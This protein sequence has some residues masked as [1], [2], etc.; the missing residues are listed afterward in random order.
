MAT[1]QARVTTDGVERLHVRSQIQDK[2]KVN[3][4][5]RAMDKGEPNLVPEGEE[6]ATGP[7]T[8]PRR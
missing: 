3:G 2:K 7:G 1:P 4:W 6:L 8:A 5:V